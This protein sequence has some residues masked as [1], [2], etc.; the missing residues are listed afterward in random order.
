MELVL[1]IRP[2]AARQ[3]RQ[4]VVGVLDPVLAVHLGGELVTDLGVV[5]VGQQPGLHGGAVEC[6][7]GVGQLSAGVGDAEPADRIAGPAEDPGRPHGEQAA[8]DGGGADP[9]GTGP[10]GGL[11]D[12]VQRG[13]R[14][15]VE[16]AGAA[17]SARR[18][19]RRAPRRDCTPTSP[20]RPRPARRSPRP[21]GPLAAGPVYPVRRCRSSGPPTPS[22]TP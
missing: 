10:V 13:G 18:P 6:P 17:G 3:V 22:Y 1:Q 9:G 15:G 14:T 7:H 21:A 12:G 11:L 5:G 16:V 2:R 19:R 4:V 8:H 20:R